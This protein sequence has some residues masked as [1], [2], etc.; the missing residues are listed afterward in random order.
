MSKRGNGEGSIYR[1]NN[2]RWVGEMTVEGRQRKFIYGKTRKEV[3]DKLQAAIQE[4]QQGIV[5]TGT[6]RQTLEQFLADWL[7]NS[8][9]Q[10]VRPRTYERYE[11]VVRLLC[12]YLGITSYKSSLLSMCRRFIRKCSQR[13]FP[14]RQ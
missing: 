5:L 10:S 13:V 3:Q 8:Q 1:R 2:G 12:R 11:V 6:A 4:K 14:R 7:E 9:K